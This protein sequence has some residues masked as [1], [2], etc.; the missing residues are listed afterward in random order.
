VL[1]VVAITLAGFGS[2]SHTADHD[3]HVGTVA[4][5]APARPEPS[6]TKK[7]DSAGAAVSSAPHLVAL[8]AAM[9]KA[10]RAAGPESGALVFDLGSGKQLY[11]VRANV[12]R[13]PASVE[14]LYTTVALMRILGPNAR[15]HTTVLGT[16]RLVRGVWHGN[17]YL[18]GGGDPTF[19]DPTF[20]R[21]WYEGYGPTAN[22]LVAQ[23]VSKGITRVTGQVY[24]DES[25]FDLR[26]GGLMTNY[27]PDT[28][29]FGGQLSALVYDHGSIHGRMSP[30]VF[31]VKQFVLT[32]R[33]SDIRATWANRRAVTPDD[34]RP[35]AVVSS[36]PMQV[37]TRLMDVP[38]DDLFAELF[39][40]QLGKLF[41]SGGSISAGA[42]VIRETIASSYNLH[43]TILDGSGL[44][45]NDRSSP[46]EVVGLLKGVWHAPVGRELTSSLPTVGV[47][48]TVQAIGLKTAA[49]GRCVA[50][51][52]TLNYVTNLAGYCEG[53]GGHPLAFALMI[54]GPANYASILLESRMVGAIANY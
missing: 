43:P 27:A 4:A 26:R 45:R 40:K 24:A 17:L 53:R 11:G 49:K 52:G 39:T 5:P 22:Q 10:L 30:A 46:A 48:G 41:G 25:L 28:P 44:S 32:M 8:R 9:N 51:T 19:S 2:F 6:R 20:D 36:P 3:Q 14:K 42:A 12:G 21:V 31:A 13:P 38:S 15:L 54:D 7:S 33:G 47:N 50:K 34:A 37:M 1:A 18:R 35:L 29:D 23:L 16:G